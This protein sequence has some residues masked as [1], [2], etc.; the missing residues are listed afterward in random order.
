MGFC[1]SLSFLIMDILALSLFDSPPALLVRLSLDRDS[2]RIQNNITQV[3]TT[4]EPREFEDME[5]LQWA[6]NMVRHMFDNVRGRL[7]VL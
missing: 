2:L 6:R 4:G 7:I 3:I 5:L 1:R